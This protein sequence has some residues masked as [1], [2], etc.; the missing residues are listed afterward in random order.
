MRE[1]KWRWTL[2]GRVNILSY[3]GEASATWASDGKHRPSLGRS[4]IL[5]DTSVARGFRG[6][7]GS[8][9]VRASTPLIPSCT[10]G[11]HWPCRSRPAYVENWTFS[12]ALLSWVSPGLSPDPQ[13]YLFIPQGSPRLSHLALNWWLITL[14]TSLPF[15]KASCVP[16]NS[17]PILLSL[18]FPFSLYLL[19]IWPI[20]FLRLIYHLSS[21][22][23]SIL[24]V[25]LQACLRCKP[26]STHHWQWCPWSGSHLNAAVLDHS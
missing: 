6:I 20:A 14:S 24:T 16:R 13:F 17:H 23:A 7:Q 26:G 15:S 22:L 9:Y 3:R 1:R 2:G 18:K 21:P 4:W 5:L 12:G 19:N 25:V 11:S 10:S 8:K